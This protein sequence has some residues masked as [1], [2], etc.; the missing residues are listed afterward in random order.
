MYPHSYPKKN[1]YM[2]FNQQVVIFVEINYK[3]I[4]IQM[5]IKFG[6][7]PRLTTLAVIN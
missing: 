1:A 4:P 2:N 5:L 3:Q 6:V 7:L